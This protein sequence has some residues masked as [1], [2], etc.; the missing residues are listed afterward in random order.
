MRKVLKN[1][2]IFYQLAGQI[3]KLNQHVHWV[4]FIGTTVWVLCFV[5]VDSWSFEVGIALS[6]FFWILE[7]VGKGLTSFEIFLK[8]LDR[9]GNRTNRFIEF[10]LLEQ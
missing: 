2:E 10:N 3:G 8:N 5:C 7:S 1:L 6:L 9:L 4:L